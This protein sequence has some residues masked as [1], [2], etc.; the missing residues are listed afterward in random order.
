MSHASSPPKSSDW[1]PR[2]R[3]SAARVDSP[4]LRAGADASGA[5]VLAG[6]IVGALLPRVGPAGFV[7]RRPARRRRDRALQPVRLAQRVKARE[8]ACVESML[9]AE[10]L[11]PLDYRVAADQPCADPLA[12]LVRPMPDPR[13]GGGERVTERRLHLCAIAG[14]QQLDLPGELADCD[15]VVPVSGCVGGADDEYA[16]LPKDHKCCAAR[17]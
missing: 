7:D 11:E 3:L 13:A 17:R 10:L 4:K 16:R 8:V 1:T 15:H 5:L 2:P 6:R 14:Q 12:V 9:G